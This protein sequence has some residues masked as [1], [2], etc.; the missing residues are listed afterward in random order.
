MTKLVSDE[1]ARATRLAAQRGP[2]DDERYAIYN[3]VQLL[4]SLVT[5]DCRTEYNAKR[6]PCLERAIVIIYKHRHDWEDIT[7]EETGASARKDR[8]ALQRTQP[9]RHAANGAVGGD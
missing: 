6:H 3:Y 9:Q 2:F 4:I 8:Q 5:A 7:S 1:I